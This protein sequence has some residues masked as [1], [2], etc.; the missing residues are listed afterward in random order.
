MKMD[1]LLQEDNVGMA[2]QGVHPRQDIGQMLAQIIEKV[3]R[4]R[5]TKNAAET[6]DIKDTKDTKKSI[7]TKK[8][9]AAKKTAAGRKK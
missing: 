4:L 8:A 9:T 5:A 2:S 6:K 7:G 3:E 1:A